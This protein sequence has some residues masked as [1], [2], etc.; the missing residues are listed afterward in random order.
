MGIQRDLDRISN[1]KTLE[2]IRAVVR[3]YSAKA[4]GNGAAL[5]SG[6]IG[7]VPANRHA[8]EYARVTQS[9]IIDS[10]PRGRFLAHGA[11]LP[12]IRSSAERIFESQGV[13]SDLAA[14]LR[15]DFLYGDAKAPRD[16]YTSIFNCLWCEASHDFAA[17]LTGDVKVMP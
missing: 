9:S 8:V 15:D 7:D 11:V 12:A 3:E 2:D 16:S 6:V 4:S 5:Y 10:S 13:G 17:S 14:K 1:A